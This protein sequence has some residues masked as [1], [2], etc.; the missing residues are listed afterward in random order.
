MRESWYLG[1]QTS[2]GPST[3]PSGDGSCHVLV[4]IVK[5]YFVV[6]FYLLFINCTFS[7]LRKGSTSHCLRSTPAPSCS[8]SIWV[9]P[10]TVSPKVTLSP[11]ARRRK[12][13]RGQISV[14]LSEMLSCSL[15][16]RSSQQPTSNGYDFSK[17]LFFYAS[18]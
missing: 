17:Y 5:T 3:Q 15:F 12:D 6:Y 2:H 11:W 1:Q 16:E 18:V 7:D 8:S 14:S 4:N 13:T 10:L 9:P